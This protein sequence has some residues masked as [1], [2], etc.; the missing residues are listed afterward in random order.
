MTASRT[1]RADITS[2]VLFL[3]SRRSDP[4]MINGAAG[5]EGLVWHYAKGKPVDRVEAGSPGAFTELTN[6]ELRSRLVEAAVKMKLA[7]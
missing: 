6:E 1:G 4:C 5:V 7:K 3:N 2:A